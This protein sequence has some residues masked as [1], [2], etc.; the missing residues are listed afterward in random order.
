M[1]WLK[2]DTSSTRQVPCTAGCSDALSTGPSGSGCHA[3]EGLH[4][5]LS[6]VGMSVG[7]A[8]DTQL[9]PGGRGGGSQTSR[10]GWVGGVTGPFRPRQ[11]P[12]RAF[13]E[14]VHWAVHSGSLLSVASYFCEVER[15]LSKFSIF[16][17]N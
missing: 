2:V 16:V 12:F 15:F 9:Q 3:G 1:S 7:V 10:E 13:V 6:P 17:F 14:T 11:G 8:G 5:P 4:F